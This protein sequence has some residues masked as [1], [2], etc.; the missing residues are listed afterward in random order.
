MF[1]AKFCETVGQLSNVLER[2]SFGASEPKIFMYDFHSYSDMCVKLNLPSI[3]YSSFLENN[4]ENIFGFR[5]GKLNKEN[6]TKI[7]T[8]PSLTY[9]GHD[10]K[11]AKIIADYR[12]A[13]KLCSMAVL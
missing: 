1:Q 13:D 6:A 11:Y 7:P 8:V 5:D 3:S 4:F 12:F 10:R 2:P 9:L